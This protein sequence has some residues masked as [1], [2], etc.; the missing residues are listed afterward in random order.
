M[1]EVT[2]D[3]GIENL[4]KMRIDSLSGG[5][6]QK[7]AIARAIIHRP[8]LLLAD[9]PTGNLDSKA[10]REIME[11]FNSLHK[12]NKTTILLVTHDPVIASY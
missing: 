3:L 2:T 8:D 7:A 5:Q 1:Q 9:E 12:Q 11:I 6:K 4:L 10:S